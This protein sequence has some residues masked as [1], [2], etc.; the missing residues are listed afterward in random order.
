MIKNN[1]IAIGVQIISIILL[2]L[3][4]SFFNPSYDRLKT[5]FI[6][7][8]ILYC[9]LFLAAGFLF[10]KQQ[11]SP[12]KTI[13]SISLMSLY[14][15]LITLFNIPLRG[16]SLTFLLFDI[17]RPPITFSTLFLP[18]DVTLHVIAR[19]WLELISMPLAVLCMWV[20]LQLKSRKPSR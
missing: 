11:G 20:G 9:L 10:M 4:G 3:L 17:T 13:L 14:P 1:L 2:D 19:Y 5:Y 18:L 7:G 15:F 12:L 6:A 16:D 8:F